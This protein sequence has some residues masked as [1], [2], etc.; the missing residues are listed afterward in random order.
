MVWTAPRTWVVG[1]VVTDSL[2]NTHG[3]DQLL[4]LDQHQHG[5]GAGDG[6]SNIAGLD[7]VDFDDQAG[8]P[9]T[10]GRLQRNGSHLEFYNGTTAEIISQADAAAG[11]ASLRTLGSGALQ[12]A[13]GDHTHTQTDA[14]S[15]KTGPSFAVILTS[16]TNVASHS[17]T[18]GAVG[19]VWTMFGA[20]H[21]REPT[22]T[23][24][25]KLYFDAVVLETRT[26]LTGFTSNYP[27][28]GFQSSP[29]VASHTVKITARRTAGGGTG[30]ADGCVGFHEISLP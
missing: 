23:Y 18:P 14:A 4:A 11:V 1:E 28:Q 29:T 2:L 6:D 9:A 26:G 19:R 5:G 21:F 10:T 15:G 22:R 20:I 30:G 13:A 12:G 17:A 16:E 7:T 24:E 25:T 27:S 3:R 8:S